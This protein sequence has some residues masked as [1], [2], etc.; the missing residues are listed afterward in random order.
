VLCDL[1]ALGM[2]ARWGVMGAADV[3]APHLRERIWIVADS[4]R[5]DRRS[6]SMGPDARADGRYFA[7][8]GSAA[9]PAADADGE[10]LRELSGRK[11]GPRESAEPAELADDGGAGILSDPECTGLEGTEWRRI[12]RAGRVQESSIAGWWQSEPD[13]GRVAHGVA[14]RVDRLKCLGNGQV[15]QCAAMA[16]RILSQ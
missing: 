14:A 6:D 7:S 3:G 2:D 9:F 8:G 11:R 16:W 1:S 15:P 13:V 10:R 4:N 12:R 5:H